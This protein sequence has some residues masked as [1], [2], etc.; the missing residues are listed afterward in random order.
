MIPHPTRKEMLDKPYNLDY[1]CQ[2]SAAA[3]AKYTIEELV[4]ILDERLLGCGVVK[5]DVS[6]PETRVKTT[7]IQHSR[8]ASLAAC[9]FLLLPRHV[10]DAVTL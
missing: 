6:T 4:E 2:V 9:N 10:Q 7:E 1:L 5:I 3:K 8:L